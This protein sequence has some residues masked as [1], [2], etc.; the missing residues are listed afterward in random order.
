MTPGLATH[1]DPRSGGAPCVVFALRRESAPFRR[2]LGCQQALSN[3]PCGAW[4]CG[5]RRVVILE[6][7]TGTARTEQALEWLL[8]SSGGVPGG[9]SAL[10]SAGFCGALDSDLKIADIIRPD[11]VI[12]PGHGPWPVTWPADPSPCQRAR[13]GL[14][15]LTAPTMVGDPDARQAMRLRYQAA[16]VDMEAAAV[17]RLCGRHGLP[18]GCLRVVSDRANATLSPALV[19]CL[20]GAR[21]SF[22]GLARALVQQ[23]ILAAEM[24]RLGR[25]TGR[26]ARALAFAVARLLADPS[27]SQC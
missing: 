18:F 9:V 8:A 4:L 24:W 16:A 22:T 6:T 20:A 13:P 14:R 5:H 27:P 17:A 12:H 15:L 25:D 2:L 23:P 26:A 11:E 19:T 1:R 10:V 21:V 3:A 7:G